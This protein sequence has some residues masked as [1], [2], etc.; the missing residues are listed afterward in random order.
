[1]IIKNILKSIKKFW[2]DN[3]SEVF[4]KALKEFARISLIAG[5]AVAVQGFYAGNID[6]KVI[7]VAMVT[8]FV[9]AI[10]KYLHEQ[11]VLEEDASKTLGL[12][13]F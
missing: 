8:A 13:R 9:K 6:S 7:V 1:M 10:D 2:L 11:G 12:T 5:V 3:T 4:R